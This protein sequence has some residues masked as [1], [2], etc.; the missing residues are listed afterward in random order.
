MRLREAYPAVLRRV[1]LMMWLMMPLSVVLAVGAPGD[2]VLPRR[3]GSVSA[4][5]TAPSIFPHW[6]HRINYRCD[7]CHNRLFEMKLGANEITMEKMKGGEYCGACH[8]GR[9]AFAVDFQS[10]GR[11][12]VSMPGEPSRPTATGAPEN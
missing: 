2:L 7:A 6:V 5:M 12:H 10:C 11:C 4:E 3:E 1:A 8:N 9:A